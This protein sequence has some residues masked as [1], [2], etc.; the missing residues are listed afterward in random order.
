MKMTKKILFSLIALHCISFQSLLYAPF[1][2]AY[3]PPKTTKSG[4]AAAATA[5]T[6]AAQASTAATS[7]GEEKT[8]IENYKKKQSNYE[9]KYPT[10]AEAESLRVLHYKEP[11]FI[12]IA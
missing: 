2:K 4:I 6:S 1:G 10:L 3:Q 5:A 8:F 12:A 7:A 9:K 11:F